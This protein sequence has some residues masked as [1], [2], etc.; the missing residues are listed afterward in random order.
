MKISEKKEDFK[1]YIEDEDGNYLKSGFIC[2]EEATI[3]KYITFNINLVG[4]SSFGL[5]LTRPKL[6]ILA[7]LLNEANKYLNENNN[8]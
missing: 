2:E 8:N 1:I 5:N 6:K 4:M 7:K 3:D